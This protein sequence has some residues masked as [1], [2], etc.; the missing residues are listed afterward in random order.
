M[1]NTPE[2]NAKVQISFSKEEKAQLEDYVNYYYGMSLT[3]W[4]RS[5]AIKELRQNQETD[6]LRP[7]V[8]DLANRV[9]DGT[10]P[11]RTTTPENFI[12]DLES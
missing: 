9:V 7:E 3:T 5:N 6:Q 8:Q 10:E 2:R 4:M 1:Q 12:N 11:M